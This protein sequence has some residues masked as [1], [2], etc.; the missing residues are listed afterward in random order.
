MHANLKHEKWHIKLLCKE[1]QRREASLIHD[2]LVAVIDVSNFEKLGYD[3]E[4]CFRKFGETLAIVIT[5]MLSQVIKIISNLF[6]LDVIPFEKESTD[7][8]AETVQIFSFIDNLS[9]LHEFHNDKYFK[10]EKEREINA[11]TKTN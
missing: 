10:L 6:G 3:A 7:K 1:R 9:K 2:V 8:P 5:C 11:N 4:K